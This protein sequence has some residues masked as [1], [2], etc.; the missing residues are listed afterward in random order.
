[1]PDHLYCGRAYKEARGASNLL[2][3]EL[4]VVSAGHGIVRQGQAIAPYGLTV[5]SGKRDS[6]QSK[7]TDADWSV[8]KWWQALGEY[9]SAVVSLSDFFREVAAELVLISLSENYAKLLGQELAGL[10][11]GCVQRIRVF[12]AGLTP[13]LPTSLQSCLMPYDMRLNG[14][15]SPIRG[16]MSDFSARALHHFAMDL[17]CGNL[18]GRSL[19]DDRRSIART[20]EAWSVPD[21]PVRRK[22]SDNDV[23]NFV[24]EN[25]E[26]TNGRSGAS[27]RFL[28][29]SGYACEQSRFKG[30]FKFAA[31]DRT[32]SEKGAA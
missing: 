16:T 8:S 25:W 1:M 14:S 12:G 19:A 9:S 6:V 18:E 11:E 27:L 29:D 17:K 20:L 3:A 23:V 21:I 7:I 15:D 22:M 13:H 2:G 32:K 24:L 4:C 30:L 28:R 26:K 5:A 10:D 31:A